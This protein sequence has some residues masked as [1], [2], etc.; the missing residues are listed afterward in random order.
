MYTK[1]DLLQYSSNKHIRKVTLNSCTMCVIVF[2]MYYI[3]S[4][5]HYT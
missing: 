4:D 3:V 5:P 2:F 1:L